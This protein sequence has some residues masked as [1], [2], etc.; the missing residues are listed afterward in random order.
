[1]KKILIIILSALTVYGFAQTKPEM[2]LVKGG[3]FKMGNP[4]SDKAREGNE[5]EHPVHTVKVSSFYISKYEITV[6]QFKEFLA[7]KSYTEFERFGV[8]HKLPSPPDSTW[9]QGHPDAKRY[10]DLQVQKWWGWKD[11]YPMF[12]VTWYDAVAYCNWL[13]KKEGL[14]PCYSINADNGVDC[15]MSKNGY[16][17]PTEAEWE[18][19]ARGGNKSQNYRFSGSND[20]NEVAWVDDNTMMTGPRPVGT[21]KPNELG[22][23]DMSGNVWEW[24]TDYYSPYFYSSATAKAPNPVNNNITAYRSLRGGSWHYRVDLATVYSRDGPKP[25]YTNYNYGFRVVRKK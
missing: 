2:V 24:C 21:K 16:R 7:D 23:Y 9:W 20:Y 18:Y 13:S 1:M 15:D 22:I 8:K 6:K 12:H 17:L 14:Q 10:W 25:S 5:D 11:N 4:Y 19:A 3:T